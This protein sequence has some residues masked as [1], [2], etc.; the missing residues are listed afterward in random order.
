[1]RGVP[2]RRAVPFDDRAR[3]RARGMRTDCLRRRRRTRPAREVP[4]TSGSR[5]RCREATGSPFGTLK[6]VDWRALTSSTEAALLDEDGG[7]NH[8]GCRVGFI[9]SSDTDLTVLVEHRRVSCEVASDPMNAKISG[10]RRRVQHNLAAIS[11]LG[12]ASRPLRATELAGQLPPRPR[13]GERRRTAARACGTVVRSATSSR[14]IQAG[15]R[16]RAGGA[17]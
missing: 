2:E 17:N 10:T 7:L 16:R 5:G 8:E 4:A 15:G 9:P 11:L 3:Q 12:G 6:R 13:F 1:M 14:P